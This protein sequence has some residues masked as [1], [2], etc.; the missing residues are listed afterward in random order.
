M[1]MNTVVDYIFERHGDKITS[2]NHQLLSPENL[3]I[4]AETIHQKGAALDN[5]FGFIDGTVR[6][7]CRPGE[8]QR[9]VYNGHKRVHA[10]KFQ[11]VTLPN[12]I[13]ANMFGPIEGRRH[14]SAM[15]AESGLLNDLEEFAH[16][17]GKP[18][19]LYGDPAYPL[20]IHLQA[21]YRNLPLTMPM[22]EFNKSM[23]AVRISV[24]WIFGDIINY[25]K[26]LDFKK[27][28]KISLSS[29]GKMYIVAS[30]LRNALTCL[31]SNMTSDFFQ[32]EPPSLQTY[33]S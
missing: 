8:M 26:F 12:G 25:F 14:D 21:P 29:V 10:L 2:W 7:I 13:I 20:R 30:L 17:N 3:K 18:M 22:E 33:F 16:W 23:S 28:L 24:E 27:N 6:Q 1:I 9:I 11:S 4:Y 5:C 15:L 32:L 31:Q 19:C